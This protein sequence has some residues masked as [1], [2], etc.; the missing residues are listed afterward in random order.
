MSLKGTRLFF[1]FFFFFW[2]GGVVSKDDSTAR[3]ICY[4]VYVVISFAVSL[5][6]PWQRDVKGRIVYSTVYVFFKHEKEC[7]IQ[8]QTQRYSWKML[9]ENPEAFLEGIRIKFAKFPVIADK[10]IDYRFSKSPNVL[11]ML[12]ISHFSPFFSIRY[13]FNYI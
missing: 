8:I 3:S 5:L 10:F 9:K 6:V 7:F 12:V 4:T 13:W 11:F 1:F 2:G